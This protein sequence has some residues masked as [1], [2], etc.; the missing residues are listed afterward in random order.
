MT[1][2]NSLRKYYLKVGV[3]TNYFATICNRCSNICICSSYCLKILCGKCY[4]MHAVFQ[5]LE[6]YAEDFV[7]DFRH[8]VNVKA[9]KCSG[10][11]G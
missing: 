7:T 11:F 9:H 6:E 8:L 5:W 2:N 3:H 1:L 10:I 4:E